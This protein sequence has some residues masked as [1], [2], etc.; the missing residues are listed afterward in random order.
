MKTCV[1]CNISKSEIISEAKYCYVLLDKYPVAKGHLLVITKKHYESLMEI[2]D[3]ELC[4][5]IKTVKQ[6]EKKMVGKLGA[7]GIDLKHH[8]RPFLKEG[9]LVKRHVHFHL[10]PRSY[11]DLVYKS[12]G[13]A[14]RVT[15]SEKE[16][17][18]LV[19]TLR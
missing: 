5:I 19:K 9:K 6:L 18:E 10:I 14:K 3:K 13:K 17:Q 1:F 7:K 8:Y 2:P 15:L 11:E 16:K 12:Q 4:E